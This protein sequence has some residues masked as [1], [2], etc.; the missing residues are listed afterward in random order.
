MKFGQIQQYLPVLVYKCKKVNEQ[1]T[2]K[3]F[4]V[5]LVR[6][7]GYT[8]FRR[9]R[10]RQMGAATQGLYAK[11]QESYRNHYEF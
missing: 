9:S 6:C 2:H 11:T 4:P 8:C 7:K 3:M 10:P 5:R 1:L